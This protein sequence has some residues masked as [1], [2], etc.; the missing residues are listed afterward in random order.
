MPGYSHVSRSSEVEAQLRTAALAAGTLSLSASTFTFLSQHVPAP[1]ACRAKVR[2]DI[3]FFLRLHIAQ[4]NRASAA[5][6]IQ[7]VLILRAHRAL[8]GTSLRRC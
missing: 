8:V 6:T 3:R 4:H 7:P 1:P 2:A 5:A